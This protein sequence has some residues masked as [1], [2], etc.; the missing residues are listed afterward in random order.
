[1]E[2]RGIPAGANVRAAV[3]RLKREGIANATEWQG[4]HRQQLLLQQLQPELARL[5][6]LEAAGGPSYA[7]VLK[8]RERNRLMKGA[9]AFSGENP[10]LVQSAHGVDTENTL[11]ITELARTNR[12]L[13]AELKREADLRGVN[14]WSRRTRN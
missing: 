10:F 14:P 11:K 4:L 7:D 3:N 9:R 5:L 8:D 6:K 1:M 2:L 12:V 13:A